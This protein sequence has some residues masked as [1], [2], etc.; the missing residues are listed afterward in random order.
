MPS[1]TVARP[2]VVRPSRWVGWILTRAAHLLRAWLAGARE[3]HCAA[4]LSDR[5]L[6]D[7]GLTRA[8]LQAE[9]AKPFW[10]R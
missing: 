8:Q 1:I 10:R 4:Q 2:I 5:D 7:I 9:L 3:R 6:S